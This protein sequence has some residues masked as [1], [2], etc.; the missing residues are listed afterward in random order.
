MKTGG[1]PIYPH[2]LEKRQK[3]NLG[4]L[5]YLP[6][7]RYF[8][9]LPL[10]HQPTFCADWPITQLPYHNQRPP[11]HPISRPPADR[12]TLPA[13]IGLQPMPINPRNTALVE[14]LDDCSA[15]PLH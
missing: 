6:N 13:V 12:G 8:P 10:K 5:C 1:H 9:A 7:H 14:S 11:G 3:V 4:Y 15:D 2:A